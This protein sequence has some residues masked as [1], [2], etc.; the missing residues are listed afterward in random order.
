MQPDGISRHPP[1][2]FRMGVEFDSEQIDR[3]LETFSM[4]EQFQLLP[5][6]DTSGHGTAVAGI[7]AVPIDR[8]SVV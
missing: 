5:S 7:A 1:A 6:V 8:K 2:G 4:Q 3:A